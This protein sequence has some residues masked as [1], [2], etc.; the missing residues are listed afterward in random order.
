MLML[1]RDPE[2]VVRSVGLSWESRLG[3]PVRVAASLDGRPLDASRP[4]RI[5]IPP[6]DPDNLH[7][8]GAEVE[9]ENGVLASDQIALG[10]EFLD[11]ANAQLTAVPFEPEGDELS[12][13]DVVARSSDT[14]E[15]LQV[16][17]VDRGTPEAVFVR[18]GWASRALR[19]LMG[20]S[21]TAGTLSG[22][23]QARAS[24]VHGAVPLA[25]GDRIR[26][27]YPL[28]LSRTGRRVH[29]EL[30][31]LTAPIDHT[32]GG[33]F[34]HLSTEPA[35]DEA[36]N[37][38]RLTDAVAIAGSQAASENRPRAVVLL[39]AAD[40]RDKDSHFQP[41]AVREYLSALQVPLFV[42]YI[43][44]AESS[45]PE[46]GESTEIRG[47]RDLER[48][49]DELRSAMAR[50]HIVWVEGLHLPEEVVLSEGGQ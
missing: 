16:A 20:G 49:L 5:A 21:S 45:P 1:R 30:F 25:E 27:L 29:Y 28:A 17:A 8:F 38:P 31:V 26:L 34:W 4:S 41:A 47:L 7:I 23:R 14:G 24:R 48:A 6:L 9:F 37:V 3:R 32:S 15:E 10:G 42:W 33:L 46:W 35:I 43:G 22:S 12:R 18:D 2:G 13:T 19:Q 39:L 36:R 50:Q 44:K 40:S 11:R